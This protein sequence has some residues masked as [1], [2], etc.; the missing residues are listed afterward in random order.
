MN[1]KSITQ[2]YYILA[3]DKTGNMPLLHKDESN[4]G[5]LVAGIMDL[6]TNE[7]I[8]LEKKK[9]LVNSELPNELT[10]LKSLYEYLNE[11]PRTTDKLM[12]EYM[13]YG[14][15]MKQFIAEVGESLL[16]DKLVAK[17]ESG[18]LGKKT[19]YIPEKGYKDELISAVKSALFNDDTATPQDIALIFI[20]KETKNL[21]QY[22]SKHESE[23]AKTK[24]KEMK[25]NCQNK[26]FVDMINYVSD[27]TAIVAS[28]IVT[29]SM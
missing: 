19:V 15:K 23:E 22:L 7:V 11:K 1:R 29:T 21:N 26:Q 3:V 12:S 18:L 14:G 4:A 28:F 10:F 8:S 2:E 13:A 24:L 16:K 20:L 27:M 25:N 5:L 6:I 9:I 17:D